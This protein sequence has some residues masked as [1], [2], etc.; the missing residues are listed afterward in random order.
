MGVTKKE[1][2]EMDCCVMILVMGFCCKSVFSYYM[3]Y[4]V[5]HCYNSEHAYNELMITAK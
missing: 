5:K 4:T 1:Y 2:W 3:E